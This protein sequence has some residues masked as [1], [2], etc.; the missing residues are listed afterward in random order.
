[1]E[2]A[3]RL[4]GSHRIREAFVDRGYRGSGYEGEVEVHI[5][6]GNRRKNLS[7]RLKRLRK[8]RSAI[9]PLI[10]HMKNDGR[11][12]RNYLLGKAGDRINVILCACGQ[13]LRLLLNHIS[14]GAV[15]FFL[16][17][18]LGLRHFSINFAMLCGIK[19]VQAALR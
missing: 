13:N 12:G 14:G 9:E 17:L 15:L 10:G 16:F 7:S 3:Q 2:Q 19:K 5:C 4:C 8:R 1:M 6:D 18:S 11:L